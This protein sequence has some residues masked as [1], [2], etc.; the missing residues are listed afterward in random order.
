[1]KT[2]QDLFGQSYL[3]PIQAL[4]WKPPFTVL[5]LPEYGKDETRSWNTLYRGPVLICAGKKPY[6]ETDLSDMCHDWQINRI[7]KIVAADPYAQLTGMA[8]A[9]GT[10]YG[11]RIMRKSDEEKTFVKYNSGLFVHFYKD[12]RRIEPF[13][14]KG[15]Q[16]WT[17]VSDQKI[18]QQIKYIHE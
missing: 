13:E 16:K 11:T 5:M 4:T 2:H 18:L 15:G 14:Y 9:I 10:L 1:M 17:T 3:V 8:I 6:I 12:V 7:R